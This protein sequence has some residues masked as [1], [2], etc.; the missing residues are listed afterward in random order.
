MS[1]ESRENRIKRLLYRSQYT[2]TRETDLLLGAFARRHLPHFDDSML[3]AYEA[4]IENSDPDLYMWISR[5]KPVPDEWKG[6]IMTLL[7]D[8]EFDG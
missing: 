3:D 1:E 5:R 2:G 6:A 7:Q 8:F 4:L